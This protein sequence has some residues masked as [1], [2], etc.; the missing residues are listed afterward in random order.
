MR[1]RV[2]KYLFLFFLIILFTFNGF[3]PQR[4]IFGNSHA[5]PDKLKDKNLTEILQDIFLEIKEMGNYEGENFAKREFFLE[6]DGNEENKEEQVVILIHD[7]MNM[8]KMVIQVTYFTSKKE[9]YVKYA[10]MTKT[11]ETVF[12]K[13]D[14]ALIKNDYSPEETLPILKTVLTGIKSKKKILI[15]K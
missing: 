10:S 14:L 2:S 9:K 13:E 1:G 12:L 15:E 5:L 4:E 6:L 11:I 8:E 3:F 7:F